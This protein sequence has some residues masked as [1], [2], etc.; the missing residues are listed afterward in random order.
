MLTA[1]FSENRRKLCQILCIKA[2]SEKVYKKRRKEGGR[3]G[4]VLNLSVTCTYMSFGHRTIHYNSVGIKLNKPLTWFFFLHY[5]SFFLYAIYNQYSQ[6]GLHWYQ[7]MSRPQNTLGRLFKRRLTSVSKNR[8]LS[9]FQFAQRFYLNTIC[10]E[11]FHQSIS[12][13]LEKQLSS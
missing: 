6:W 2:K 11:Q 12:C 5:I 7:W 3:W 13:R 10:R 8:V 9:H 1:L 4:A